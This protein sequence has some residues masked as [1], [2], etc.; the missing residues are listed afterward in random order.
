MEPSSDNPPAGQ[1]PGQQPA[2]PAAAEQTSGPT[3]QEVLQPGPSLQDL[4]AE[5]LKSKNSSGTINVRLREPDVFHGR[6]SDNVDR[7]LF[8]VDQYLLAAGEVAS[9]RKVA[10]A[11]SLLRG[12][13]AIW[14]E[15]MV[16]EN[17]MK[18]HS[19]AECTWEQFKSGIREYFRPIN[20][21]ERARDKLVNLRQTSSVADY[22]ARFTTVAFEVDDLSDAEKKDRFFR[23]LKPQVA[24]EIA[25]KGEPETF[26][27]MV[28]MAERIDALIYRRLPGTNRQ[29][30]RQ[31][32]FNGNKA[33]GNNNN[34]NSDGPTPM[35]LGSISRVNN[36][37]DNQERTK[38][39]PELR[40]QLIREGKCLY[41]REQ[42]HIAVNCPKKKNNPNGRRQ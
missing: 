22:V 32:N 12:P 26:E 27:E 31:V 41:C 3:L 8:Q 15:R 5:L 4:L 39:T 36:N 13:A 30:N 14:W 6:F 11:G 16:I 33:N 38:L 24:T 20:Y 23:G 10:V 19:E 25:I 35:E 1:Q 37:N 34:R 18:G 42:G 21:K 29:F 17:A 9:E 2:Q 7:W 40:Q 28:K